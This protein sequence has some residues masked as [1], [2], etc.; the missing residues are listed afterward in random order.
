MNGK[1]NLL[2][3]RVGGR[4]PKSGVMMMMKK[5]GRRDSCPFLFGSFHHDVVVVVVVVVVVALSGNV[6]RD[7]PRTLCRANEFGKHW[8]DQL[9]NSVG[10]QQCPTTA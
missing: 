2:N 7:F 10:A 4:A 6:I 9:E 3:A 5:V 8:D 1:G